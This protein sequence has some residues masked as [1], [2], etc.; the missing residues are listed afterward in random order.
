MPLPV[1]T[2]IIS[3]LS[4]IAG[5]LVGAF[6]SWKI[7]KKINLERMKEEYKIIKENRKYEDTYRAKEI[8]KNANVIRLDISTAL[9]Q[10]IR[11]IK[12]NQEEKKYLYSLPVNKNYSEAVASLSDRYSL[13]EL[14]SIYQLYGIIEKVNRDIHSWSLGDDKAYEKVRAGF[15]SVLYKIY[16]ENYENII[17]IDPDKICYE[18]LYKNDYIKE[19]YKNILA[20]LD[21][22]CVVENLLENNEV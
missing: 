11:S 10:S 21:E 16:N 9:F 5:S 8:C 13:K 17:K 18:D 7:S 14:S 15:R 6:C 2:S 3:A 12:N 4:I 1:V 20:K 19:S 22:L